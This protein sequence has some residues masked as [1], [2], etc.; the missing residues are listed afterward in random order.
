MK[1]IVG[2]V[3]IEGVVYSN[4]GDL[5]HDEF[6]NAFVHFVREKG[7]FFGGGTNQV[8]EEGN[9]IEDIVRD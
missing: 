4:K 1:E 7:W 9:V 6:I 5:C 3:K 2:G 8:D